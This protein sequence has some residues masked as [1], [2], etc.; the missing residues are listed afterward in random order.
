M[1]VRIFKHD[2]HLMPGYLKE[3][4]PFLFSLSA[5][6]LLFGIL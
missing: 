6:H 2:F 4:L 5:L 3:E 1:I